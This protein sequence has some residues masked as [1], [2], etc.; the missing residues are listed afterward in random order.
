MEAKLRDF[1]E[2]LKVIQDFL[3]D[4][5][6]KYML[7]GSGALLIC[8][9]PLPRFCGDV[10]LEVI[11]T[12]ENVKMFKM[13]QDATTP[14][15]NHEYKGKKRDGKE[16]PFMFTYKD[17]KVNVWLVKAFNHTQWV[18]KNNMKIATVYSVLK[19]KMSYKRVK[20]FQDLQHIV[21]TFMEL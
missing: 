11:E 6:Q 20:D 5:Q 12:E 13:L 19:K 1:N 4:H 16:L 8:G 7:V 2:K 14:F 3:D 17:I 18:W 9:I 21:K 10:D 15:Y